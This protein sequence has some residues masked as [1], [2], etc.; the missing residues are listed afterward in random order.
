MKNPKEC[1]F[2]DEIFYTLDMGHLALL[3]ACVF[4]FKRNIMNTVDISLKIGIFTMVMGYALL[5]C[6]VYIQ[7]YN[8]LYKK[9]S[10]RVR[11]EKSLFDTSSSKDTFLSMID[12]GLIMVFVF[13]AFRSV[14]YVAN[15]V[16][17][18]A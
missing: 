14:R 17:K 6:F 11:N 13:S 3:K 4:F 9:Y 15:N 10:N 7:V 2:G 12:M 8:Y 18:K 5:M 1:T 16:N